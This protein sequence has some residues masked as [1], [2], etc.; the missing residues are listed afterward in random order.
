[1]KQK[2]TTKIDNK[3][4]ILSSISMVA[5]MFRRALAPQP[6][7]TVGEWAD[8]YRI[9][10]SEAS[11]ETGHYRTDRTPY[12]KQIMDDLSVNSPVKKVVVMAGAQIG[13]T[14]IGLCWM[15]YIMDYAPAPTLYVINDK[16]MV[17]EVSKTRLT[18][19]INT[20][21]SIREKIKEKEVRGS[22]NTTLLKE[23]SG[24]YI[25]LI[26]A[27]VAGSLA[28]KPI[29]YV[30]LDE[31]DRFPADVGG[32]GDPIK[33]AEVRTTTFQGKSKIYITSTPSIKGASKIDELYQGTDMRKYFMPCPHCGYMHELLFDNMVV[34][35]DKNGNIKRAWL[36]CPK[37]KGNIYNHHKT[38]ML[39]QGKWIATNKEFDDPTVVGYYLPGLCAPDGWVSFTQIAKEY[40]TSKN[41]EMLRKTFW[42]TRL[43]LPYE[44]VG[45]APDW[46]MLYERSKRSTYKRGTV[47]QGGLFLTAGV[48]VQADR[49][50]CEV[51]A[52]GRNRQS[53]SVDYYVFE[54]DTSDTQSGAWMGLSKLLTKTFMRTD[55]VEMQII[56]MAVDRGYRKDYVDA[57]CRRYPTSRVNP[58]KGSNKSSDAMD[59]PLSNP[60]QVDI[61]LDN[62]IKVHQQGYFF[63]LVGA[64]YLKDELYG[65]LVLQHTSDNELYPEGYC[66]FPNNYEPY[67]YK[68][69]TAER[70]IPPSKPGGKGEWR[71]IGND[72]RNEAIDCRVYARSMACSLH[73][74]STSDESWDQLDAVLKSNISPENKARQRK[75]VSYK[76]IKSI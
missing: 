45:E 55:G 26:G 38:K 73:A 28:N 42:N 29:Q 59:Y 76:G 56:K 17:R 68:M 7:M 66:F 4:H 53:W 67:Y 8:K 74:D 12:V 49:T 60:R 19:L 18:P 32:E 64:S 52:W 11:A 36:V 57:F 75:K 33:L 5:R 54:G 43:G 37:C 21:P 1:M 58:V 70:F 23:F 69:L 3:K 6:P 2:L 25:S 40:E 50:E 9:L 65:R 62:G 10:T 14:E 39:A 22:G 34:K 15:G 35:R 71:V 31:V 46:E 20:V 48:D 51:V 72:H 30:Y 27:N 13:K 44:R 41:N 63:Y 47:P 16:N 61:K 24:G